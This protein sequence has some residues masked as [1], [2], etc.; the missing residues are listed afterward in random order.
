M[1]TPVTNDLLA[2]L[3]TDRNG[4]PDEQAL[5]V[6]GQP[7]AQTETARAVP[8]AEET[9][10][11]N[12]DTADVT[13]GEQVLQRESVGQR[14]ND[15]VQN[16]EQARGALSNILDQLRQTPQSSAQAQGNLNNDTVSSLLLTAPA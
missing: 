6:G 3:P 8:P 4:Q 14:N 11:G 15:S 10:A 1:I 9:S 7:A 16:E 2:P 13:R 12:N 5:N